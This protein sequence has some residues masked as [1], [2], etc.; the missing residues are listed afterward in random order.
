MGIEGFRRPGYR[1]VHF[2][3]DPRSAL[4]V[5]FALVASQHAEETTTQIRTTVGALIPQFKRALAQTNVVSLQFLNDAERQIL[6]KPA[7]KALDVVIGD[8]L[9]NS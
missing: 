8:F 7:P 2:E 6:S 9:G 4:D 1:A 3:L 5:F